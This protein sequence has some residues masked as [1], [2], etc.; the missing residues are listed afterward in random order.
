MSNPRGNQGIPEW[1]KEIKKNKIELEKS[2]VKVEKIRTVYE[3]NDRSGPSFLSFPYVVKANVQSDDKLGEVS[4]K[5]KCENKIDSKFSREKSFD[6]NVNCQMI[7]IKGNK[8]RLSF[9]KR[10]EE[11]LN[12]RVV[13]L[14]ENQNILNETASP[15]LKL[16]IES[17][18]SIIKK[19]KGNKEQILSILNEVSN[20][21]K[22]SWT[23][24]EILPKITDLLDE[25]LTKYIKES[26]ESRQTRQENLEKYE[27]EAKK[28]FEYRKKILTALENLI[29]VHQDSVFDL[30]INN[31]KKK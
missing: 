5:R 18:S 8:E 29:P 19:N 3:T 15:C 31:T 27:K 17:I 20:E 23:G 10:R 25:I 1:I 16:N 30:N 26:K 12:S 2:A 7:P 22:R 6:E 11:L 28:I 21:V 24:Y 14:S 13:I 4:G 9:G